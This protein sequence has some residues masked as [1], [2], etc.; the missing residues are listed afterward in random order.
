MTP[1][2]ATAF[3][4]V[5][6]F[7]PDFTDAVH[8]QIQRLIRQNAACIYLDMPLFNPETASLCSAAELQ[9]FFFAGII[10]E[11]SS[12]DMLRLQ[13]VIN[14][15]TDQQKPSLVTDFSKEL[16]HYALGSSQHK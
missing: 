12:G 14:P 9:G 1:E 13:Y 8:A 10:P 15:D 6:G 7:G 11:T 3:I 16:F 2:T 5:A 4:K